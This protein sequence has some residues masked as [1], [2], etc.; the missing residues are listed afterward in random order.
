M[1]GSQKEGEKN[2]VKYNENSMIVNRRPKRIKDGS[3]EIYGQ[4]YKQE[5][6]E[7]KKR[8]TMHQLT[9][10][11]LLAG[12]DN[13]CTAK[14][15]D[16][17]KGGSW[18]RR[19]FIQ[20]VLDNLLLLSKPSS[21]SRRFEPPLRQE[22]VNSSMVKNDKNEPLIK[23]HH[24]TCGLEREYTPIGLQGSEEIGRIKRLQA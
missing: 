3:V 17:D 14:E 4:R 10:A 13:E 19:R 9:L 6:A 5:S 20:H 11:T 7:N 22:S 18:G 8:K 2:D 24:L 21:K 1:R 16:E 23:F 12:L 15:A